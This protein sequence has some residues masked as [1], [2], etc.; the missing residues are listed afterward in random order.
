LVL[1]KK[2]W[3]F[4]RLLWVWLIAGTKNNNLGRD[5]VLV[6]FSTV[7]SELVYIR[8]T[9]FI[10]Y[11]AMRV[12]CVLFCSFCDHDMVTWSVV[13]VKSWSWSWSWSWKNME[14]LVLVLRPR[15]LILVLVLVL[16][17]TRKSYLHHCKRNSAV[18][19]KSREAFVQMQWCGWTPK[20]PLYRMRLWGGRFGVCSAV[21]YELVV[22]S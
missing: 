2:S 12:V 13:R 7:P 22:T 3:E 18:A 20:T 17:L 16:V 10:S 4:S 21:V 19:D 6:L 8:P 14:V 11:T 1:T 9:V 15:V 5:W